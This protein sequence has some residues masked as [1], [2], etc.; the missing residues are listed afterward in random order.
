MMASCRP[1]ELPRGSRYA[2][3]SCTLPV[4]ASRARTLSRNGRTSFVLN[5]CLGLGGVNGKLVPAMACTPTPGRYPSDTAPRPEI[6]R[7]APRLLIFVS[8][9][10]S[11]A[12]LC[13]PASSACR[14]QILAITFFIFRSVRGGPIGQRANNVARLLQRPHRTDGCSG[15]AWREIARKWAFRAR[16]NPNVGRSAAQGAPTA[17]V[18]SGENASGPSPR[19]A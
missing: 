13:F 9:S 19:V 15:R 14:A 11:S 5:R 4:L 7:R 8:S 18:W 2:P 16:R 6:Q 17:S 3:G 10:Y 1:L 12:C